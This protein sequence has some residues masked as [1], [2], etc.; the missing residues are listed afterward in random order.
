[1][2]NAKGRIAPPKYFYYAAIPIK[3]DQYTL[4]EQSAY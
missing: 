2:N 4:I 3:I 1:M